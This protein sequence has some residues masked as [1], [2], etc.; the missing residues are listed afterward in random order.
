M[1]G[2]AGSQVWTAL[3]WPALT[4]RLSKPSERL[5]PVSVGAGSTCLGE[6]VAWW[7]E[8]VSN[9]A[10]QVWTG[11]TWPALTHRLSKPSER[12][13]P[14]SVGAGSMC[15]WFSVGRGR[16][17]VET[18]DVDG[19]AC[20]RP[21]PASSRNVCVEVTAGRGRKSVNKCARQVWTDVKIVWVRT[22]A[23]LGR[24]TLDNVASCRS[25]D[26]GLL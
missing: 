11:V 8:C 21:L 5:P 1:W 25:N 6:R 20:Q 17:T 2:P 16:A 7:R 14:V 18:C 23:A 4:H 19:L 24:A 22:N 15:L 3:T 12:L 26:T 10:R 13:P 9:C